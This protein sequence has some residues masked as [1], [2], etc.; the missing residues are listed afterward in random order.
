MLVCI[1]IET[2][3]PYLQ[4]VSEHGE[5]LPLGGYGSYINGSVFVSLANGFPYGTTQSFQIFVSPNISLPCIGMA[6]AL[7][8]AIAQ[9]FP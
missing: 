9:N 1:F 7:T 3:L 5:D 8:L 4:A 6:P 2:T